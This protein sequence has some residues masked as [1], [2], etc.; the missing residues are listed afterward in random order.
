MED[1]IKDYTAPQRM[2]G[3]FCRKCM[4]SAT[5][6]ALSSQKLK[7]DASEEEV[8]EHAGKI[9]VLKD[10]IRYNVEA[11]L[12]NITLLDTEMSY[13]THDYASLVFHL[14]KRHHALKSKHSL[15]IHPR[16]YASSYPCLD[17]IA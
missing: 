13:L 15:P 7:S 9:Q 3:A 1:C 11:P 2:K 12:V 10:A 5:L 8:N 16:H 4:L 14:F 6:D 17:L